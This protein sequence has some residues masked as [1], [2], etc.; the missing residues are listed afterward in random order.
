MIISVDFDGTIVTQ[1]YP[2]IGKLLPN[3]KEVIREWHA[4]GHKIIIN[5]C[6]INSQLE[7]ARKFLI[8]H[9]IPF[10]A[11]NENL[12]E[13]IA[14]FKGD[15][16]KISADVY[17]DDRGLFTKKIDWLEIKRLMEEKERGI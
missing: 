17:I 12:P 6:R 5:T 9:N 13:R 8:E 15:M 3:A 4:K 14:Y 1:N 7:D 11:I 2:R 16:R 10:D